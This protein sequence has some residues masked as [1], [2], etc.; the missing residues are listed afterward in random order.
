MKPPAIPPPLFDWLS[1]RSAGVL[2]HPTSLPGDQ[3]VGTL[4]GSALRFLDFLKAAGMSWWQVCPLGPTGYG[5]SPYQCFSAFAGNP[6]LVDLRALAA[7]GLLKSAEIAPLA[8]AVGAPVDFGSLYQ[9]KW[10]LLRRAYDRHKLAGSPSLGPEGFA[11][12]KA[13]QASWLEPYAW[14]RALKD[15]FGGRAWW[16]WPAA[17]PRREG[18]G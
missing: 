1:S 13:A 16:E 11:E 14:F 2:L 18:A 10:P 12:F 4:D 7:L 17:R 15:H 6:Y 3:G 9:L 8:A 5:D